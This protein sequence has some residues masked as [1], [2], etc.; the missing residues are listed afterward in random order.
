MLQGIPTQ[1]N[2]KKYKKRKIT[3]KNK[4]LGY[5]VLNYI[6]QNLSYNYF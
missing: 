1:Q 2:N 6:I 4:E 5:Y 3:N